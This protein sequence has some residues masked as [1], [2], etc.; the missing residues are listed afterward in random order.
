MV[1]H[2]KSRK[3]VR[4]QCRRFINDNLFLGAVRESLQDD[5]SLLEQG[6]I[7]LRGVLELV[8]FVEDEFGIEVETEEVVPE[9]LD[10]INKVAIYVDRKIRDAHQ[11]VT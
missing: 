9:N 1:C 7:D 2:K 8:E 5:D 3:D 10:S 11:Y 4:D 6:H